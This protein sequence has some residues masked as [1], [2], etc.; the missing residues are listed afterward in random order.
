MEKS[1]GGS[2]KWRPY[3]YRVWE[4]CVS[5]RGDGKKE[6]SAPECA[7]RVGVVAWRLVWL[8]RGELGTVGVRL[9]KW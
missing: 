4:K 6:N 5:G 9:G 8:E 7:L 1:K 3:F 2:R